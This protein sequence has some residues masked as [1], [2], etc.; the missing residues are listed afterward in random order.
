M[1]D[2]GERKFQK[3]LG[4]IQYLIGD[5]KHLREEFRDFARKADE[6]RRRSDERFERMMERSDEERAMSD[7]RFSVLLDQVKRTDRVAVEVARGIRRELREGQDQTH[8]LLGD[9]LK[10]LPPPSN[11]K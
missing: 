6:D 11:G 8:R 9:I 4:G 1:A 2:N 7:A 5:N 3:V 10:R